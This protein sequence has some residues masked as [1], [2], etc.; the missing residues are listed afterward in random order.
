MRPRFACRLYPKASGTA[1]QIFGNLLRHQIA[2]L[3]A[4]LIRLTFDMQIDPSGGGIA[5]GG[6][7][8][9]H[10]L[11]RRPISVCGD[12]IDIHTFEPCFALQR[13]TL[14]GGNQDVVVRARCHKAQR[15][16]SPIVCAA[17]RRRVHIEGHRF[18]GERGTRGNRRALQ[19]RHGEIFRPHPAAKLVGL[20]NDKLNFA[21]TRAG[22]R[23]PGNRLGSQGLAVIVANRLIGY[24]R[25]VNRRPRIARLVLKQRG[26]SLQRQGRAQAKDRTNHEA[27]LFVQ[28][29]VN[30]LACNVQMKIREN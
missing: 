14:S 8:R 6:S 17:E 18:H 21:R 11:A 2:V 10:R 28:D 15:E 3:I 25:A 23:A 12:F 4:A 9:S 19:I 29:R 26:G 5:I 16:P 13:A 24:N 7:K 20:A 27:L 1:R 22:V 30:G